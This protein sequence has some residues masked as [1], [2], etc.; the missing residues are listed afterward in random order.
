MK[1]T[2]EIGVIGGSG[3]YSLTDG[4]HEVEVETPYG[5]ASGPLHVETIDGRTVAF[6]P[7]HGPNHELPPH[8]INYRAN[9]WALHHLGVTA[10][11]A[12]FAAG[13]LRPDVHPGDL[14]MVDQFVDLTRRGGDTFSDGPGV[15]HLSAADPYC[16]EL[17]TLAL[18]VAR[19]HGMHAH[20]GGT[21]VVIPG[22]RFATRA[23]SRWYRSQSWD[24]I[25]MTQYPEVALCRELGMCYA[26]IGLIT[27]YDTG[28]DDDPSHEPVTQD[29]VFTFFEQQVGRLR[30]LVR[31]MLTEFPSTRA[32]ACASGGGP[33]P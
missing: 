20:D 21:V 26:G 5:P 12:P 19:R 32:C 23:E 2:A 1:T 7:R 15:F 30:E 18:A 28:V 8:R 24:L 25:N 4:A 17:R 3:F 16:P 10:V 9:C 11:L 6:V 31:G 29:A 13:S 27:D 22:P 33:T 14:V